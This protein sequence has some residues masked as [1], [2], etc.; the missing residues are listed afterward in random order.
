LILLRGKDCENLDKDIIEYFFDLESLFAVNDIPAFANCPQIAPNYIVLNDEPF[1]VS[2]EERFESLRKKLLILEG[3]GLKVVQPAQRVNLIDNQ[4]TVYFHG[5]PLTSIIGNIDI[6]RTMGIPN[7]TSFHAIATA[8]YLGHSPIF[9]YGLDL[10]FAKY[11]IAD[12]T[13]F[14][15]SQ[16]RYSQ[17]PQARIKLET[18]RRSVSDL[19]GSLAFQIES[20]RMFKETIVILGHQSLVDS[21]PKMSI[22]S[23]RKLFI[24]R[25][26]E[27]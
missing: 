9:L 27:R 14:W 24:D 4:N 10:S 15:L 18:F 8:K 5:N 22:S 12:E 19:F 6:H 23:F 16:E 26:N 11:L 25:E 3:E 1:W 20:L 2:R 7:I 17:E 21:V 13:G